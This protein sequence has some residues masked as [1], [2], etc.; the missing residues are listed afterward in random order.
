VRN[1]STGDPRPNLALA[2]AAFGVGQVVGPAFAGLLHDWLGSFVLPSLVAAL[3]LFAAAGLALAAAAY[4]PP[5]TSR[6]APVT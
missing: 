3:A 2:T 1:L 4:R 5:E 6:I